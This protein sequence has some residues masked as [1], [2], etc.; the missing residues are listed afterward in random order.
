MEK[1]ARVGETTVSRVGRED[2]SRIGQTNATTTAGTTE[3]RDR[4][5]TRTNCASWKTAHRTTNTAGEIARC[6]LQS[7][8]DGKGVGSSRTTS[9]RIAQKTTNPKRAWSHISRTSHNNSDFN[10]EGGAKA[11]EGDFGEADASNLDTKHN[12][13]LRGTATR[14]NLEQKVQDVSAAFKVATDREIPAE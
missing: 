11:S 5:H 2:V 9:E 8:A 12:P 6:F 14:L 4:Y 1:V 3:T 13:R 10:P 7:H